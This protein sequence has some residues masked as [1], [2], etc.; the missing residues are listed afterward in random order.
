MVT[1][2]PDFT[3]DV[4]GETWCDVDKYT[5]ACTGPDSLLYKVHPSGEAFTSDTTSLCKEIFD[6]DATPT[7]RTFSLKASL[8]LNNDYAGIYTIVI[9]GWN[10]F[11]NAGGAAET[12]TYT[13]TLLPDCAQATIIAPSTHDMFSNEDY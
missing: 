3:I 6:L 10:N 9:R 11:S 12:I 13:Y 8:P 7:V 2:F 4:E 1:T 5:I